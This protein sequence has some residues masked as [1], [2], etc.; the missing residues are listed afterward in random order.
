MLYDHQSTGARLQ[1]NADGTCS[2]RADQAD[3]DAL[4]GTSIANTHTLKAN[5]VWDLPDV[6]ATAA[7]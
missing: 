5:F 3:A 2:Y 6:K 7:R 4:L 1:R